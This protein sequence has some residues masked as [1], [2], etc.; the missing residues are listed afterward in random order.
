MAGRLFSAMPLSELISMVFGAKPLYLNQL[1][2]EPP[3]KTSVKSSKNLWFPF[4]K[5]H[6]KMSPAKLSQ[7]VQISTCSHHN[8]WYMI[9]WNFISGHKLV[10][11]NGEKSHTKNFT[12]YDY[13]KRIIHLYSLSSVLRR[14]YAAVSDKWF[15]VYCLKCGRSVNLPRDDKALEYELDLNERIWT[16]ENTVMNEW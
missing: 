2:I 4:K 10:W 5:M 15:P 9:K 13:L 11:L 1:L 6:M 16:W 12:Y 7:F 3:L 8:L 14:Y